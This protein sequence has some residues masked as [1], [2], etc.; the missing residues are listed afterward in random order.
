MSARSSCNQ[1]IN[2]IQVSPTAG[3]EPAPVT[4]V[5]ALPLSHE[6]MMHCII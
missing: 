1:K 3:V 4:V 6:G 5:T 2:Q